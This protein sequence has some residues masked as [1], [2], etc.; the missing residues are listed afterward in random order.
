MNPKL[1]GT[2]TLTFINGGVAKSGKPYL[3][4]SNGRAEIFINLP[5]NQE[6]DFSRF[7]EDDLI[8]LEVSAMVGSDSVTL[9][10][11]IE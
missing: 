2:V 6:F 1:T 8:T 7:S 5:K 10:D 3:R 9:V 11:V 4:C